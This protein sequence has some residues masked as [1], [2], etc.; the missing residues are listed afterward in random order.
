MRSV[1]GMT[2]SAIEDDLRLDEPAGD[3]V[4]GWLEE[5]RTVFGWLAAGDGAA[6][7]ATTD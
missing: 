4:L 3:A 5:A 7:A 1:S 6:D 2:A